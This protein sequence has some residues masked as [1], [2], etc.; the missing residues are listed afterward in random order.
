MFKRSLLSLS[1]L[2]TSLALAGPALAADMMA[3]APAMG[4]SPAPSPIN[5]WSGIYAGLNAGYGWGRS[6]LSTPGFGAFTVKPGGLIGGAQI[7]ANIQLD[8][9]VIG[10]EGD[11]QATGMRD[12]MALP[13]AN[14]TGELKWFGTARG[15]AGVALD[16]FMPYVTG[17]LAFGKHEFSLF[18]PGVAF[19]DSE[20]H[21]GWTVGGGVEA[22]LTD[23]VSL[24]AEYL[25]VD[26]GSET[27]FPGMGGTTSQGSHR[28]H[29][30]RA[31]VNW[32]F[33]SF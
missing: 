12:G 20:T 21:T 22:A 23:T 28:F 5:N 18:G 17:G 31:G 6:R 25:R 13:G 11:L 7:G 16:S 14:L 26:L 2:A 1:A 9:V 3:P 29:T 32:R 27:Y 8:Q 30:V 33:G 15:R 24:K 10:A 19:T 4:Y